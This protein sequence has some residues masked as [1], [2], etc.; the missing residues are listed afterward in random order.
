MFSTFTF[1]QSPCLCK[2]AKNRL[3]KVAEAY[4]PSYPGGGDREDEGLKPAWVKMLGQ[5]HLKPVVEVMVLSQ[6]EGST[7]R[8]IEIRQPRNKVRPFQK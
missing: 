2:Y 5:S 3:G 8:R 1:S 4:N 7:H 6:L